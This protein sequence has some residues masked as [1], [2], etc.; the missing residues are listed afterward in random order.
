VDV[1]VSGTRSRMGDQLRATLQAIEAKSGT[2]LGATSVRGTLAEIFL[3]EDELTK[4]V[5]GLLTPLRAD[6]GKSDAVRRDVPANAR[7]FELFLRGIELARDMA[8]SPEARDVFQQAL[9]QDPAF[10]PAWA[11]VGRCHR[12]IGKYIENYPDND[13]RAEDAFRRALALSPELPVAH[14]FYTHFESEHGRSDAAVSRLLQHAKANR[15]DAQ[16]FAALVHACR[17]SG[18]MGASL[19]AHN[20]ARRLDPS[21]LTSVEFSY[22]MLGQSEKLDNSVVPEVLAAQSY[23]RI[24]NGDLA[25]ARALIARSDLDHLPGGY[26]VLIDA[27]KARRNHIEGWSQTCVKHCSGVGE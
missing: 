14:R 20:E 15:N 23:S 16:M 3:F 17:Y 18:L 11:W 1:V 19:A 21:V 8:R 26:R 24:F 22:L 10:A 27:I 5:V 25:G 9:D 13:K 4:G 6:S 12:V 2:V 7:A